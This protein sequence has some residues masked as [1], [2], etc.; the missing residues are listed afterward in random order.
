MVSL[1]QRQELAAVIASNSQL[2]YFQLLLE[3]SPFPK[4]TETD[5][6]IHEQLLRDIATKNENGF[7]HLASEI[8]K[9]KISPDSDWCQD[10]YLIFLLLL[11]QE[12]F[13]TKFEFLSGVLE[14]RTANS[15]AV[16]RRINEVF[17]A[18]SRQEYN[19]EGEYGF[20]KI[21]FLHLLGK[22]K[23]SESDARRILTA[24]S[25][26]LPLN[27]FSPFFR[28]LTVKAYDLTLTERQPD[29][30]E[31]TT[32]LVEKLIENGN[33]LSFNNWWKVFSSI[34]FM[35]LLKLLMAI[36]CVGAI[37]FMLGI[38]R[39]FFESH[40]KKVPRHRPDALPIIAVHGPRT[41]ILPAV[42][43]LI[44]SLTSSI[45]AKEKKSLTVIIE[46]EKFAAATPRF[47]VE[48]SHI[49]TPI[50]NALV[51]LKPTLVEDRSFTI[52]NVTQSGG[53]VRVIIPEQQAGAALFMALEFEA[54][55]AETD[56]TMAKKLIL[57]PLD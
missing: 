35:G 41:E 24:F 57:R 11:G 7:H 22:L 17:R 19:I 28:I 34:P 16:P 27:S 6:G 21:P 14:A 33:K 30:I 38:G 2:Q 5:L 46:V 18:L 31:D 48:V 37:M 36:G 25:Q 50:R 56:E 23:V 54:N 8:G 1:E 44:N 47:V 43:V 53:Y 29:T 13:G 32:M 15:N 52:L 40:F 51:F 9:R 12:K 3:G 49:D 10:D 55:I 39:G 20:L 4:G 42:E 45:N 26:P